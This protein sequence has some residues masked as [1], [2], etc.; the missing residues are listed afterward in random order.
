MLKEAFIE[1]DLYFYKYN[2]PNDYYSSLKK[3]GEK[4]QRELKKEMLFKQSFFFHNPFLNTQS[5][6]H[7][8]RL[9]KI[10][11][12][13][14]RFASLA[15]W[16]KKEEGFM[17]PSVSDLTKNTKI[18]KIYWVKYLSD[19]TPIYKEIE[20]NKR[21]FELSL[22]NP[23]SEYDILKSL[24]EIRTPGKFFDI[25]EPLTEGLI[26]PHELLHIIYNYHSNLDGT[27]VGTLRTINKFQLILLN[28]VQAIYTSQGVNVSSKHIEIV[29]R[30]MTTKV[31]ILSSGNTPFLPSEIIRLPL[32]IEISKAFKETT[33]RKAPTYEP[34]L[35]SMTSSSLSKDGFLSAAGFQETKRVLL[36]A[37]IEGTKDWFRGLKECIII[38]RIIPAGSSF[39][40]Y[41]NYLD[42]IYYF[43]KKKQVS[44][45]ESSSFSARNFLKES[46]NSEIHE[47]LTKYSEKYKNLIEY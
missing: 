24:T 20:T 39:L 21:R 29:V 35:L 9:W 31:M 7:E 27:L 45:N 28:S 47:K 1:D 44:T 34:K 30:Q 6:F 11:K 22:I 32:I 12:S 3:R 16:E 13:S 18:T 23:I 41:K 46:R 26:D 37:A 17:H 19:K 5:V 38:G 2:V 4:T 14:Q 43:K 42:T 25:G 40:R 33:K 8:N 10:Q 15:T 36:K